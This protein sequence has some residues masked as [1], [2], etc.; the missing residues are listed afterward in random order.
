MWPRAV[1][2]RLV[3]RTA[4]KNQAQLHD[5]PRRLSSPLNLYTPLLVLTANFIAQPMPPSTP[6]DASVL[7]AA[8]TA[9]L[10][11]CSSRTLGT[12][13]V[14]KPRDEYHRFQIHQHDIVGRGPFLPAN[15]AGDVVEAATAAFVVVRT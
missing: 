9:L 2:I 13:S 3:K 12:C 14:H 5:H 6:A 4:I 8:A 10:N 11:F 1:K 15:Q 7:L